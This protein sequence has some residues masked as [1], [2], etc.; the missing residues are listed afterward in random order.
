MEM[1]NKSFLK[2][3]Y[4]ILKN[5]DY[6]R[7]TI[8]PDMVRIFYIIEPDE[9]VMVE[10]HYKNPKDLFLHLK[11]VTKHKYTIYLKTIF[12]SLF[13]LIE[14]KLRFKLRMMLI[15]YY[16]SEKKASKKVD[17][18]HYNMLIPKKYKRLEKIKRIKKLIR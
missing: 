3:L 15:E 14:L 1:Y 10:F 9:E 5:K 4:L 16:F 17:Y 13:S 6:I 11:V 2:T 8:V 12:H 7:I 18:N